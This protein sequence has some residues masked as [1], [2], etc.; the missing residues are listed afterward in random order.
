MA[1]WDNLIICDGKC[2]ILNMIAITDN[3]IFP[4]SALHFD[5]NANELRRAPGF[6]T[7]LSPIINDYLLL[8]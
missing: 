3:L 4:M 7:P 8:S 2:I 1:S 5:F 6:L